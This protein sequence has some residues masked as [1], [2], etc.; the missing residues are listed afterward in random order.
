M[1]D[2][3]LHWQYRFDNYRRAFFLLRESFEKDELT[4]L[5]KEGVIQCFKYIFELAWKTMKDYR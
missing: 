2:Q 4:Q 5:E 1:P 3:K